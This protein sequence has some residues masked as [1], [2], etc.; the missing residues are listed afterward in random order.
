MNA[1]MTHT[2]GASTQEAAAVAAHDS[3]AQLMGR[4][5]SRD[6][7]AASTVFHRFADRLIALARSRLDPQTRRKADPEDVVQSAF[8]S[9]FT[10]YDAGRLGVDTWDELWTLLTVITVRKSANKVAQF[11][12][13]RRT[14]ARETSP[15][16][17][18]EGWQSVLEAVDREPTASQAAMLTETVEQL[19][20]MLK[21]AY[22][23]AIEL[24]LQGYSIP[25]VATRLGH[26]ER[27]V[28]RLRER[29]KR[30]L[31]QMRSA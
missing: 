13:G 26:S 15:D 17:R 10:R 8:R 30:R 12:A 28:R 29:V 3:F 5:R 1:A 24:S 9:F 22:R 14:V 31:L 4:L 6:E 11:R 20:Q 7:E 21:P 23:P 27:T 25:E 19:M 16:G 18:A 2:L